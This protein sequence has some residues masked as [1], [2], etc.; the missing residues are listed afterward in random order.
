MDSERKA[1]E[2]FKVSLNFNAMPGKSSLM[3]S[4]IQELLQGL[5]DS[6]NIKARSKWKEELDRKIALV[7]AAIERYNAKESEVKVEDKEKDVGFAVSP[8]T[9]E[10]FRNVVKEHADEGVNALTKKDLIEIYT[11]LHDAAVKKQA[12]EKRRAERKQRHLQDDLRYAMKK[13]SEPLDIALPYEEIVPLIQHLPEYQAVEDDE[14]R[15]AAFAKSVCKRW[16]PKMGHPTTS[17]KRKEPAR[18][19]RD[20][21]RDRDRGDRDREREKERDKD[22]DQERDRERDREPHHRERERDRDRAKDFNC[23][24]EYDRDARSSRHHRYD[25]RRSSR[26]YGRGDR[27][28]DD[29][30]RDGYKSSKHSYHRD[31]DRRKDKDD[32][33]VERERS[34]SVYKE[35]AREKTGRV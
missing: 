30:D 7:E 11:T 15:R 29:K 21:D 25:E 3:G 22:R 18:D 4:P 1:R 13:L 31:D 10:E 32:R 24:K 34:A 26:D 16:L 2:A 6:R 20:G 5:V 28:K 23:V 8:E 17:R 14:G 33:K 19:H 9:T 35:D 12:E 27:D